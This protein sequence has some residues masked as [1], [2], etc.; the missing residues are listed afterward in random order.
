MQQ[1]AE[2]HQH[3]VTYVVTVVIV[4]IFKVIDINQAEGQRVAAGGQRFAL[5]EKFASVID[6]G[7]GVKE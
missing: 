4:E 2:C 6:V 5:A 3:L 1:F 7:Q